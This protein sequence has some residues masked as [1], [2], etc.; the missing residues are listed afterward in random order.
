MRGVSP[1]YAVLGVREEPGEASAEV[2][3][4]DPG[5]DPRCVVG[6]AAEHLALVIVVSISRHWVVWEMRGCE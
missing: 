6:G 4:Y 5:A 3:C 1:Y 2:R